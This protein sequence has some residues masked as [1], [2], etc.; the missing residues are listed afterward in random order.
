ML[1]EP[2]ESR[3][4]YS[5]SQGHETLSIV[6][7]GGDD[8][9]SVSVTY[10]HGWKFKATVNGT[11]KLYYMYRFSRVVISAG[12][13]NDF[14]QVNLGPSSNAPFAPV[15]GAK[16]LGGGGQ[17]TLV[18]GSGRDSLE[19]GAG[20]DILIGNGGNDFLNGNGGNDIVAG[21]GGQDLYQGG[22]GQA[23]VDYARS[24][25]DVLLKPVQ[26]TFVTGRLTRLRVDPKSGVMTARLR[27]VAGVGTLDVEFKGK[28]K[29]SMARALAGKLVS[30]RGRMFVV[31]A[32]PRVMMLVQSIVPA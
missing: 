9:I 29:K 15:A 30:V 23:L 5:V 7:T 2:L 22:P 21:D 3:R 13:G 17:D 32:G 4:L 16:V 1:V 12:A 8:Q 31:G 28:D 26:S 10:D 6:G 11:D 25:N 14:V 24:D 19:G 27:H 18:G 20:A